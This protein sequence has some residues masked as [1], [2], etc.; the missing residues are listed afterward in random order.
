MK[1][2]VII[3]V[4]VLTYSLSV[5]TQNVYHPV[6]IGVSA[7]YTDFHV[8]DRQFQDFF[9]KADWMGKHVPTMFKF[10]TLI[11]P[12]FN[13]N[14][15]ISGVTIENNKLNE[16]LENDTITS[17]YFWKTGLQLEY[18]FTNG[19]LLPH[20]FWFDPYFLLGA[21]ISNFDNKSYL[22]AFF[23]FGSNLWITDYLGVN[24]QSSY[25]YLPGFNSYMHYSA[26]IVTRFGKMS[27]KDSDRVPNRVD[28]CPEIFGAEYL[29]G[30]PDFDGDGIV[31]SLDRCPHEYGKTG[32]K[33]CPDSDNDGIPDI[34]DRCPDVKGIKAFDGCDKNISEKLQPESIRD[35][36]ISKNEE[37]KT[38]LTII[39][40]SVNSIPPDVVTKSNENKSDSLQSIDNLKIDPN[41]KFYIITGSFK[42][43]DNAVKFIESLKS[44]GFDPELIEHNSNGSNR[45][46]IGYY[47]SKEEA[48]EVLSKYRKEFDQKA[49]ILKN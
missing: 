44:K 30:C 9:V 31:D 43:R 14:V 5:K 38:E 25:D 22:G 40:E 19:Y 11:N 18:K 10:G 7:N 21:N 34:D 20:R 27:D 28:K 23:G 45:V 13:L 29:S 15:M 36:V 1:R 39:T 26:G 4:F 48:K 47:F 16:I 37:P 12:S 17:F 49:W 46:S 6:I 32:F 2:F 3:S 42:N 24:F 8:V 35:S 41:K 33:G